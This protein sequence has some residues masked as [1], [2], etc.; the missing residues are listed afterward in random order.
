MRVRTFSRTFPNYHPKAGEATHFIEKLWASIGKPGKEIIDQFIWPDGWLEQEFIPKHHTIRKGHHF[1]V[2][3]WFSPRVWSGKPYN[4]KQI[5]IAPPIQVKKVWDFEVR[6]GWFYL[7]SDMVASANFLNSIAKNDGLDTKDLMDWF[8]Y[9]K[10]SG[11]MQII[12]WNENIE[13]L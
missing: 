8:Q 9:P 3:D 11:E 7:N 2:G 1:K 12:C 5:I 6:D 10:D 13:Y 4:S